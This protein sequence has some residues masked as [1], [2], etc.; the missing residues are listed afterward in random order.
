MA[1]KDIGEVSHWYNKIGVAVLKLKSV[2]KVGDKIKVKHGENEFEH[3]VDSMQI[4]HLPVESAKK[5]DEVAV[6]LT[7]KAKEGA[8]IYKV[9]E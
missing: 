1:E 9:G 8:L 4:D 5:G 7:E 6:K 2:L 3:T